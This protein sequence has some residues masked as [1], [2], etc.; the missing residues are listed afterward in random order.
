MLP[1]G[2]SSE[3]LLTV[4]RR[5]IQVQRQGVGATASLRSHTE[6]SKVLERG[7][8]AT[9]ILSASSILLQLLVSIV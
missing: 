4:T 5:R 1:W 3:V 6:G 2:S 8:R 7:H 9:D